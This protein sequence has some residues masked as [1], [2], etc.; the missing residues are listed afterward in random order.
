M[1]FKLSKL[2][3]CKGLSVCNTPFIQEYLMLLS[4]PVYGV[5]VL[6]IC[7]LTICNVDV[8]WCVWGNNCQLNTPG[9]LSVVLMYIS[10]LKLS[11]SL[12][13]VFTKS[14]YKTLKLWE[15]RDL[16]SRISTHVLK[17]ITTVY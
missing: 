13:F 9:T 15:I 10:W 7:D 11:S 5:I 2:T 14:F 8:V 3:L 1:Q 16:F 6:L 17:F 12:R 4:K